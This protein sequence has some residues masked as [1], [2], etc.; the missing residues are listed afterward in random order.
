MRGMIAAGGPFVTGDDV[1]CGG[2]VFLC[3][4]GR[5][6]LL[7]G[8]LAVF[9]PTGSWQTAR[10]GEAN[11]TGAVFTL[12]FVPSPRQFFF[13]QDAASDLFRGDVFLA[14]IFVPM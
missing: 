12:I 10:G 6:H 8:L 2:L 11:G 13:G 7:Y 1:H 9:S 4:L 3:L 14:L 5:S